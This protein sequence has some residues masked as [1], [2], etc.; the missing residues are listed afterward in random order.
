MEALTE[1]LESDFKVAVTTTL[2]AEVT[3]GA[4]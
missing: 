2:V 3:A 1:W 4:V